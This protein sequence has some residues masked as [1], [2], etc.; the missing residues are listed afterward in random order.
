MSTANNAGNRPL[1]L[2]A[3]ID[4]ATRAEHVVELAFSLVTEMYSRYFASPLPNKETLRKIKDEYDNIQRSLIIIDYI[5]DKACAELRSTG[6]FLYR[7]KD[8]KN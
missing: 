1:E 8:N 7:L 3:A 4:Q 6:L 5:G 2:L